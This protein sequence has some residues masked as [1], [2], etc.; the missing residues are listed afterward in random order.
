VSDINDNM[1]VTERM[2]NQLEADQNFR[3]E[4]LG[5]QDAVIPIVAWRLWVR[6]PNE[7]GKMEIVKGR[8][9]IKVYND[10]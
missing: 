9:T 3:V 8:T 5:N 7:L 10:S 6:A 4:T 2:L 1:L